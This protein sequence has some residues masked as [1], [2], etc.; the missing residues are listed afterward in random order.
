MFGFLGFYIMAG[1]YILAGVRAV[2]AIVVGIE[3]MMGFEPSRTDGLR[4]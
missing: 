3:K 1:V 2:S 4:Q